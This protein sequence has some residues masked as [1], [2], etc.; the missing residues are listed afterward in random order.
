MT[1]PTRG[2][3]SS[4]PNPIRNSEGFGIALAQLTHLSRYVDAV[5]TSVLNGNIGSGDCTA[6]VATARA[7]YE[8]IR[9]ELPTH[10]RLKR[11]RDRFTRI[12]A[13]L[14]DDIDVVQTAMLVDQAH[15]ALTVFVSSLSGQIGPADPNGQP[16]A[17]Q[18]A[19]PNNGSYL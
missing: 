11:D 2:S 13:E 16:P 15:A 14:P 4:T 12:L 5:A 1:A 18:P 19:R 8:Q 9:T 10:F 17:A 3:N 6:F 7:T